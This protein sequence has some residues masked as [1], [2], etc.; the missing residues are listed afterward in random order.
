MLTVGELLASTA[1]LPTGAE[2]LVTPDGRLSYAD[3][4]RRS[5]VLAARM[6]AAGVGKGSRV[7]ILLP[8]GVEWAVS[9]LAAA[10]VGAL[11]LPLSTYLEADEL[12]RTLRH[13]DVQFLVV[14][15]ALL[16][17]DYLER[18][19]HAIPGLAS[20]AR[21]GPL[22]LPAVP[23]LRAVWTWEPTDR[24]W[25]TALDELDPGPGDGLVGALERA[26]S[27][28][29]PIA[30]IH[31]SGSTAA[32]KGVVHTNAGLVRHAGRVVRHAHELCPDDRVYSPNPFFWVGG[33]VHVLLGVMHSGATAL[34]EPSFDAERTLA[35]VRR[36]GMTVFLG[37]PHARAALVDAA[38]RL[39]Q[40]LDG[41]RMLEHPRSLGMTETAG[42]HVARPRPG[43]DSYG[44]PVSGIEHRIADP[45]TGASLP[46]GLPDGTPGEIWVRGEDVCDGLLRHERSEVFDADG[47]YHTGD[48]GWFDDEGELHFVGRRTD[49]IKTRG[50]NVAP[51][52]VELAL[53]TLPWVSRAS[54]V[55]LPDGEHGQIV[56][57][58]IARAP[59][60]EP[61]SDVPAALKGLLSSYKIPRRIRLVA[62]DA[63]PLLASGKLDR[64]AVAGHLE[65]G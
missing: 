63:M 21:G 27:P 41:V 35:F 33:L 56:G 64:A 1:T 9:W 17:R 39:D 60:T 19:E 29:D 7:G 30:V 44:T 36:E 8:N 62:A 5:R 50:M 24:P 61:P 57:T 14:V 28:A 6:V 25:A 23:S 20:A 32:P 10:R 59:R 3:A 34:V 52:E 18:L 45:E 2:L 31:T 15:P 49:M 51:R 47:W 53:E 55:G 46:D 48:W 54:V 26:V 58:L 65:A 40:P 22:Y 37:Q 11:T 38:H 4:E 42:S 43:S 12:A 13:G 16:G